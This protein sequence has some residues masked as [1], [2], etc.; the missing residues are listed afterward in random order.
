MSLTKLRINNQHFV[1]IIIII[2]II[3]IIMQS[4]TTRQMSLYHQIWY[5]PGP[6]NRT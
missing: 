1:Y 6:R 2:I 4:G 5:N 3:I